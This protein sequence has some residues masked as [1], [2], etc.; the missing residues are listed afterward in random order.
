MAL[1]RVLSVLHFENLKGERSACCGRL[2]SP[3]QLV[4]EKVMAR[5]LAD[6]DD[7]VALEHDRVGPEGS[8]DPVPDDREQRAALRDGEVTRCPPDR[9]RSHLEMRLDELELALAERRQV[10]KLVDRDVLLD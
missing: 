8:R 9:R 5:L 3:D 1:A 2:R 6:G 7:L 10:Q 4:V